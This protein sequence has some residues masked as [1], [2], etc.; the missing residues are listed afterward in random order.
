MRVVVAPDSYGGLL[1]ARAAADVIRAA[2]VDVRPQDEVVVVPMS[3]GGTGFAEVLRGDAEP[4]TV[5]VCGPRGL[6]VTA[7]WYLRADGTAVVESAEACG[8]HLVANDQ[9]DPARTT[10]WGVGQLLDA[11]RSAGARRV[12][13]GLGGSATVDGGAGALSGLLMRLTVAD[14]SGLKIGGEDLPRVTGIARGWADPAWFSAEAPEILLLADVGT[15]IADAPARFGPQKGADEAG[16]RHLEDAVATW[17]RVVEADV[18]GIVGLAS[19]WGSGAA[20]GLAYGLAAALPSARIVPGAVAVADALSIDDVLGTATLVITGEGRLDDAS[21]DGKVV[22]E[23]ARRAAVHGARTAAIVGEDRTTVA[24]D[25]EANTMPGRHV[26]GD[27]VHATDRLR[28]ATTALAR[29]Q[30]V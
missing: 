11:V 1:S 30:V 8:L 21:F 17:V 23:L 5:E 22:G 6:P 20:G 10:T 26:S 24:H 2:W 19:S 15:T 18:D 14:G 13:V 4:R 16:V 3:D 29:A 25:V 9:A 12:L 27:A 28:R 7:T